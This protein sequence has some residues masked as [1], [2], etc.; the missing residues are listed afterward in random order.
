MKDANTKR[1]QEE[2]SGW[3]RETLAEILAQTGKQE[4]KGSPFW[5]VLED[6]VAFVGLLGMVMAALWL[7]AAF[8]GFYWEMATSGFEAGRGLLR[9]LLEMPR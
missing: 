3:Q 8:L 6:L 1:R 9:W 7:F 5:R 2:L 4:A